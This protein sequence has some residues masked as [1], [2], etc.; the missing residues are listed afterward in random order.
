M[1]TYQI[2]R[3]GA[4]I[5]RCPHCQGNGDRIRKLG[6]GVAMQKC[7]NC[8]GKGWIKSNKEPDWVGYTNRIGR[9]R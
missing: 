3:G 2:T 4:A 1:S 6:N 7:P 9:G 5:W 8:Y